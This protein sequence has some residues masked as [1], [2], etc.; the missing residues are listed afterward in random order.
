M[1]KASYQSIEFR[2]DI[3]LMIWR[4]AG[5]VPIDD[6]IAT[7]DLIAKSGRYLPGMNVLG[8]S[9][10]LTIPYTD[11]ELERL[12]DALRRVFLVH[13]RSLKNATVLPDALHYG[14]G[15]KFEIM[16]SDAVLALKSFYSLDEARQ[17]LEIPAE[18]VIS[19][20]TPDTDDLLI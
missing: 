14:L 16:T 9:W 5:T 12:A 10:D 7:T 3:N 13:G 11:P 1:S 17:W 8:I 19:D 15:R 20:K 4:N 2:R 18:A 6:F